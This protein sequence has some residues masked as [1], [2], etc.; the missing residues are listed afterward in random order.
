[1][2]IKNRQLGIRIPNEQLNEYS[3]FCLQK[4]SV[5]SLRLRKFIELE[6]EYHKSG[7]DLLYEIVQKYE[8]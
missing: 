4:S 2:L 6:L 1:M 3:N 5:M 7:K 8:K